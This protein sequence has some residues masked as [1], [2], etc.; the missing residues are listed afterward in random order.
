MLDKLSIYKSRNHCTINSLN[1]IGISIQ[2]MSKRSN[3]RDY[4][5][6]SLRRLNVIGG[7]LETRC[8]HTKP[9][10]SAIKATILRSIT[11]MFERTSSRELQVTALFNFYSL[12][13]SHNA[14]LCGDFG[15][16]TRWKNHPTTASC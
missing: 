8:L 13:L 4:L 11:S 6:N 16:A 15:T 2:F 3:F 9:P 1:H 5:L 12:L 14:Q 7:F 10:R